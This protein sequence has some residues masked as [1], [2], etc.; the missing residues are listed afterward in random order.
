MEQGG[1]EDGARAFVLR[2]HSG[3]GPNCEGSSRDGGVG[4]RRECCLNSGLVI[5]F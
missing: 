5:Q 1:W 4:R 2:G 3:G